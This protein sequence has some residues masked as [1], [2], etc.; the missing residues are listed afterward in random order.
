V[1]EKTIEPEV[2]TEFVPVPPFDTVSAVPDQF[3]LLSVT[4]E[5]NAPL[6]IP[7][8]G[9]PVA[10]VRV[11]ELGVPNAGVISVG[12]LAKTIPPVPVTF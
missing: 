2:K 7:D 6:A 5:G 1:L 8:V 3:E 10:F 12:E 11:S 4:P 9:S